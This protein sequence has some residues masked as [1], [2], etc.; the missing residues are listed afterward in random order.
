MPGHDPRLLA[1]A[2]W[3]TVRANRLRDAG[4]ADPPP[5]HRVELRDGSGVAV[6]AVLAGEAGHRRTLD[7][8]ATRLRLE[9]RARGRLSLIN[10]ATG[11]EVA[12]RGLGP[13][14]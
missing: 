4:A 12:R 11:E 10:L 13:T 9:G 2:R 3:A 14:G 7:P 1:R 6:L 5:S 8:F